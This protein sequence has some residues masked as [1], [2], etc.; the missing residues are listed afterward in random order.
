MDLIFFVRDWGG[1][2]FFN[3][4]GLQF[5][6][7]FIIGCGNVIFFTRDLYGFNCL[8]APFSN[9]RDLYGFNCFK[10]PVLQSGIVF[11]IE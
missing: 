2:N 9:L 4:P 7:V 3:G 6:I 10:G 5:Q 11:A 1:S 8:R